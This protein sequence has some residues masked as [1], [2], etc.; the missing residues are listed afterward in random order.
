VAG[1]LRLE[2]WYVPASDGVGVMRLRLVN[3][4]PDPVAQFELTFTS[5][6]QL[7]PQPPARLVR[8]TSGCHVVAPPT[9]TVL[10]PGGTWEVLASCG[11]RPRHANDG[12]ASAFLTLPDG[13][14]VPVRTGATRRV[15]LGDAPATTYRAEGDLAAA[16]AASV[17]ARDRRLHLHRPAVLTPSGVAP[18]RAELAPEL[19]VDAFRLAE[20]GAGWH[21]TAGS[22]QVLERALTVLVRAARDGVAPR[23]GVH[24]A[25]FAWRGMHVDLARQFHPATDVEWLVDVAAWHGLNR[26]HLHL[27]DDEGWRFPVDGYPQL[28]DV[29]AW[30][31]AGLAVPPLLGSGPEPYGG[32][33]E[34]AAIRRWHEHAAA[35]GVVI[36][37]E[38]DLPGHCH[39]ALA[40]LP[41]LIDPADT[42]GATSVQHFVDNV[43]NPGVDATWPFLEAVVGTLADLFPGQWVHLGGDEVAP[44]A[45]RSSPAAQRWAAARGLRSTHDIAVALLRRI[46]EHVREAHGR[47]V[48]VWEEA[49]DALDPGHGYVVG[50]RDDAGCRRLAAAGHTV[51]A[52][53]ATAVY[54]DMAAAADWDAPGM[55]WA[56][57][58]SVADVAAWNPAAG[59]DADEAGRLRGVQ[60]CLWGELLL[61]RPAIER[62]LFPRLTVF[63]DG[64]WS[65]APT[66]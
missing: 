13:A 4:G 64:L 17:A 28:T 44:G 56:G 65:L 19:G 14:D 11:H 18:V 31:G 5:L 32:W 8:R 7:D 52:A 15:V 33:Y 50:W 49:A 41:E 1:A 21:V 2:S 53:P 27:S 10:E 61:D 26:L 35:A 38:V 37:P 22:R 45:W 40:A 29:G 66:T 63:A 30:R 60:S 42:S 23:P 20:D 58:T 54:L 9:G 51:V 16:A 24:A 55:S 25:R 43:L 48:G 34:A 57:H 6:V 36:V 47:E 39:A 46:A 3:T 59:W 12:P 62:M